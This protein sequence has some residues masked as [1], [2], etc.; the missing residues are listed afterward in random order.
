[1][2]TQKKSIHLDNF[3]NYPEYFKNENLNLKWAKLISIR[4]KC[5]LSIEQKRAKKEIGS[6]LEAS[7]KI[8]LSKNDYNEFKNIDFSELCITSKAEILLHEKNDIK[9]E[10]VK[11]QGTKC[12]VCWK[13]NIEPCS[14]HNE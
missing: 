1:M 5:N 3:I 8:Y 14:R 4:D 12:S 10:T 2:V 11:A 6:S 13:I 7:I 9:I